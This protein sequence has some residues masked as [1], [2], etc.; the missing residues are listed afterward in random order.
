MSNGQPTVAPAA[1]LMTT[2]DGAFVL[3]A[4]SNGHFARLCDVI[5]RPELMED[6]RFSTNLARVQNRPALLEN[7]RAALS[8]MSTADAVELCMTNGIVVGRINTYADVLENPD[9]VESGIFI[10][11]GEGEDSSRV[12]GNPVN[13]RG[14]PRSDRGAPSVGQHTDE[15]L[16]ELGLS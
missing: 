12:V 8:T 15:V 14:T 2:A 6:K 4:A 1:D 16:A 10:T 11:T 5:G 13:F 7:L 9:V 3:S